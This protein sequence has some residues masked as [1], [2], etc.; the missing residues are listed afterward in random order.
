MIDTE[1]SPI[2]INKAKI[3][4]ATDS[5]V[6]SVIAAANESVELRSFSEVIPT[7]N[8]IFIRAVNHNL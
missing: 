8:D 7:M 1:D 5:K 4:I 3:H 2:G 6:R